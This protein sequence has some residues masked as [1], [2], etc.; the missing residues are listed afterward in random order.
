MMMCSALPFMPHAWQMNIWAYSPESPVSIEA[1]AV[2]SLWNGHF[3]ADMRP[4]SGTCSPPL[5]ALIVGAM[6]RRGVS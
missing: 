6:G 3:M 2:E 5:S 1:E 4:V